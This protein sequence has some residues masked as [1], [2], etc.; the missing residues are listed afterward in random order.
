MK[1]SEIYVGRRPSIS[2]HR[3]LNNVHIKGIIDR[4]D[5][6][7][8]AEA[9]DTLVWLLWWRD[10]DAQRERFLID[11]WNEQLAEKVD[12]AIPLPARLNGEAG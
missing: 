4:L 6:I 3:A 11:H 9:A 2:K 12:E 7:G 5:E 10:L 8:E 1:A